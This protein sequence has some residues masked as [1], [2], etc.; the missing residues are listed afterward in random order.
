MAVDIGERGTIGCAYYVAREE[1][2]FCM[3]EIRGGSDSF[4]TRKNHDNGI[5]DIP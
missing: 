1:R 5:D 4:R 3:E 2:L